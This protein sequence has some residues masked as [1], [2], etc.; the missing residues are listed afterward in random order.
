MK[1][2]RVYSVIERI[3]VVV[4]VAYAVLLIVVNIVVENKRHETAVAQRETV[5][6]IQSISEQYVEEKYGHRRI[7]SSH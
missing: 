7:R 1:A 2:S 6:H 4:V 5:R 3:V